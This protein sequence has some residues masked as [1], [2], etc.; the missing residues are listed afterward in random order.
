M[1]VICAVRNIKIVNNYG[2]STQAKRH[3]FSKL[4]AVRNKKRH[5]VYNMN[6]TNKKA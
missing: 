1:I 2:Q 3:F 5:V 4:V 6:K